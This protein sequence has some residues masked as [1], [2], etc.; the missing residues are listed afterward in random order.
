MPT[1]FRLWLFLCLIVSMAPIAGYTQAPYLAR[2]AVI[3]IDPYSRRSS[4]AV[5]F[6]KTF[7]VL[8]PVD[9]GMK[10]DQLIQFDIK[11]VGQKGAWVHYNADDLGKFARIVDTP[12]IPG[13]KYLRIYINKQ[14]P[15]NLRFSMNLYHSVPTA[16]LDKF[17]SI[18]YKILKEDPTAS[19]D[20]HKLAAAQL[21]GYTKD[22]RVQ[23]PS[24]AGE[25]DDIFNSLAL[26]HDDNYL[27]F[28]ADSLQEDYTKITKADTL[29]LDSLNHLRDLL[30]PKKLFDS[31]VQ[32]SCEKGI[33][34]HELFGDS[35]KFLIPVFN[36]L[37]LHES[38]PDFAEGNLNIKE[39]E[40]FRIKK[41]EVVAARINNLDSLKASL[42]SISY[43]FQASSFAG[44]L[45]HAH[46]ME[47][48]NLIVLLVREVEKRKK[49]IQEAHK[50]IRKRISA[51]HYFFSGERSYGA[52]APAGQ[53]LHTASGN[54][55][56]PDLG[57][58]GFWTFVHGIAQFAIR[59]YVGVNISFRAIDKTIPLRDVQNKGLLHWSLVI[60]LTTYQMTR[61]G[62]G[63]IF[64]SMS[65]V[66]GIAY[67]WSRGFRTTIGGVLYRRD[68]ANPVK[69]QSYTIGPQLSASLDLDIVS[70]ISKLTD[71]VF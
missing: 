36:L 39:Y 45:D 6:D 65:L 66:G 61:E 17:D 52:A 14:L 57:L 28:F 21:V 4:D 33:I 51:N 43:F 50:E 32:C 5:P 29:L 54:Y 11:G 3:R 31:L 38:L 26:E 62:T 47:I 35:T 10:A 30:P 58:T 55:I 24:Y 25:I 59:P 37:Y 1:S 2:G 69:D 34:A 7:V 42:I 23:W 63:D 41:P 9:S 48:Y 70:W 18:N 46:K 19:D 67:R 13:F 68:N 64:K 44:T 40:P 8:Y 27:K 60:G 49:E 20:Y 53:D 71:K 56:I 22:D 15:P 12:A 16:V